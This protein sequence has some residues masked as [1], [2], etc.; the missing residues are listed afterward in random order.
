MK[1]F[2]SKKNVTSNEAVL[3]QNQL[4]YFNQVPMKVVDS[5]QMTIQFNSPWTVD[6]VNTVEEV[7]ELIKMDT[8]FLVE[9]TGG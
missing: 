8:H 1:R 9:S 5:R 3:H 2:A 6:Q 7:Q 4:Q